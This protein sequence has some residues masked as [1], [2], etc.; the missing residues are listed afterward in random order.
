M[1]GVV[2]T[3]TLLTPPLA[4]LS[5]LP[6]CLS[7]SCRYSV[8]MDSCWEMDPAKRATF[9]QLKKIFDGLLR[10]SLLQSCPYMDVVFVVQEQLRGEL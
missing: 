5:R 8:M 1:S 4:L 3:S 2:H 6:V 10:A 9:L 7:A